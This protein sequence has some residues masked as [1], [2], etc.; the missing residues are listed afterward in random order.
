MRKIIVG[1]RE[2]QL[3]QTQTGQVIECLRQLSVQHGIACEFETKTILTKGDQILDVTLSKVGGKGLFVKEIEQALLEHEIDIA[4]HSMKDMPFELPEGLMIGAIPSRE[5][6][7]DALI[8]RNGLKLEELPM[9]AL[10]G[11]SS[12]RREAQLRALR[13]DLQIKPLRG[14]IDTRLR[15]LEAEGF[16]A[17]IL[18]AAGLIRMGWEDRITQYLPA[19]QFVPA[20]GQGALSIECREDDLFLLELLA[21]IQDEDT[22]LAVRAERAFLGAIEGSCQIPIGAYAKWSRADGSKQLTL[23]GIVGNPDGKQIIRAARSGMN[24]EQL[25][26]EIAVEVLSLGAEQILQQLRARV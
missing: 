24:P 23:T 15:K 16:D 12:L 19:D 8:S 26:K 7:R 20:V 1:T 6:M 21:L 13:P 14:N 22:A 11:T 9:G 2:S 25:G 4:I 10:V 3:A 18:A 17:I 5:D